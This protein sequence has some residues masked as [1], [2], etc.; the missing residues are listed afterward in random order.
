MRTALVEV[1]EDLLVGTGK[2]SRGRV[3][4]HLRSMVA[5]AGVVM[6]SGL[7]TGPRPGGGQVSCCTRVVASHCS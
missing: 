6:S 3:V 1:G 7:L 2:L 4:L 5:G